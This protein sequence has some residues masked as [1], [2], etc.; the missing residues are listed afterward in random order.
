MGKEP[1][2][3]IWESSLLPNLNEYGEE[4]S[5]G[6]IVGL[7]LKIGKGFF[8]RGVCAVAFSND[9]KYISAIGCDDKHS[10]G[11]WSL[12]T[13]ELI[14]E[15]ATQNGIPPQIKSLSWAPTNEPQLLD[16][17]TKGHQDPQSGPQES[18]LMV[19]SG[20]NHLKFWSFTRPSRYNYG[21]ASLLCK[22]SNMG[23]KGRDISPTL[24]FHTC[25]VYISG[26]VKSKSNRDCIDVITGG[27]NGYLYRWR[28][29]TCIA[30]TMVIP[31]GIC[32]SKVDGDILY[33]G[34]NKGLIKMV[35]HRPSSGG[36]SFIIL[37]TFS[38]VPTI[39]SN[40]L[41]S[42]S[43]PRGSSGGS[44][45][46]TRPVSA[47]HRGGGGISQIGGTSSS[48]AKPVG[49]KTVLTSKPTSNRPL[50]GYHKV[51]IVPV[52]TK[53]N[54]NV[55]SIDLVYNCGGQVTNVIAA[56]GFGR[57][58]TIDPTQ[59]DDNGGTGGDTIFN[60]HY[61]P[62]WG[63]CVNHRQG[64]FATCGDDRYLC[65]WN[66]QSN[67]LLTRIKSPLPIRCCDFSDNSSSNSKKGSALISIG[68]AGGGV[69]IYVLSETGK[70][71]KK[72]FF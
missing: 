72:N 29:A 69:I 34:G 19:T 55:V 56:T 32:T 40:T 22:T 70:I 17:I 21:N 5:K 60:F 65:I 61:G 9:T 51:D 31:G 4:T 27:D 71:Y 2:V 54:S 12:S 36:R 7:V 26:V 33:C 20:S 25:V 47:N 46:S 68:C 6:G 53:A 37:K 44:I 24:R 23:S 50:I 1:E 41:G 48:K 39:V 3:C 35:D 16:Y 49:K 28:N 38:T 8:N 62:L 58:L 63:L 52:G 66:N 30:A 14:S 42:I 15:M 13:G 43:T 57:F 10:M 59:R 18:N 67:R 11:I 64:L 45:G